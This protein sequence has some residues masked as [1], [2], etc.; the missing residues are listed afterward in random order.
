MNVANES[1]PPYWWRWCGGRCY[2][3]FGCYTTDL[4]L[5][6]QTKNGCEDPLKRQMYWEADPLLDKADTQLQIKF[7]MLKKWSD[8]SSLL[9]CLILGSIRNMGH[10]ALGAADL[11]LPEHALLLNGI[12]FFHYELKMSGQSEHPPC[13]RGLE[14]SF[15]WCVP[16]GLCHLSAVVSWSVGLI[17]KVNMTHTPNPCP[18]AGRNAYVLPIGCTRGC[19][20]SAVW[21]TWSNE[22]HKRRRR[23]MGTLRHHSQICQ[24]FWRTSGQTLKASVHFR[25]S[26]ICDS[27]YMSKGTRFFPCSEWSFWKAS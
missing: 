19:Q 5:K 21:L 27:L 4:H 9:S 26:M 7:N 6:P 15:V 18:D 3:L 17:W 16:V 24:A 20:V 25:R 14:P 22:C 13:C 2:I 10:S 1:V 11:N 23:S 12:F 8:M